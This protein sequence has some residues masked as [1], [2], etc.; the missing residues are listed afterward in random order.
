VRSDALDGAPEE[1]GPVGPVAICALLFLLVAS[2]LMRGGNRQVALIVLEA[3]GLALLTALCFRAR[4]PVAASGVRGMLLA[5]LASSPLWLAVLYLLPLPAGLWTTLPGRALYGQLLSTAGIPQP[6]WLPASI[7]PDATLVSVLAGIPLAAAFLTGLALR[8]PQLKLVLKV[9]VGAAFFQVAVG[10]LQS[11][12]GSN[13]SLYFN[14]E[15]GGRPLGTFANT[16]HFANYLAMALA[17]Y[18]WLAW[19]KLSQ[20]RRAHHAHPAALRRAV[21]VWVAGA[22]LLLV[23]LLVSRSRGA[24]LAGLPAAMGAFALALTVGPRTR[25]WRTTLLIVVGVLAVGVALVGADALVAKF[26]LRAL[27]KDASFRTLLAATTLDGAAEFWPLG[28]GWGTYAEVYPRFQPAS[29]V[30]TADYAHQDYAQ[31]LFEGGVFAVLL[32]AAFA[33]LALTRAVLLV[34]GA[35]RNRRLRREE[36]AATIC[37]IGLAGFL[38]HSLVEFNMHIPA[39]AIVAALFAGVFLRPLA[40]AAEA[41]GD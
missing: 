21:V 36:M 34:R 25:P 5:L 31:M 2:P 16:N 1:T 8:L 40:R 23:G 11:A 20:P 12:G 6:A 10:L 3:A 39:N 32:M 29:M 38:L 37:G 19:M 33:W 13:S 24:A 14:V 17:G 27:A 28:A 22:I 30:G 26:D 4:R 15:F 9:L 41:P 18:V 7:V 35:M